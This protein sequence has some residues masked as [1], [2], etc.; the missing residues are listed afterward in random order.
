[1]ATGILGSANL[2]GTTNTTIYTV[3]SDTYTVATL[4]VCNRNATAIDVRVAVGTTDTPAD[5]DYIEY[6]VE[7]VG[8]GVLERTGIVLAAGQKI[9]V[10]ST[11]GSTSAVVYGIET[12]TA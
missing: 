2:S 10:Y 4:S 7:V 3:P 5:A 11:S 6:G 9:V 8:N 1:M 12:T